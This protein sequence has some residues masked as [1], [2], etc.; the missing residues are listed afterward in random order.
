MANASVKAPEGL[1][2]WHSNINALG[3]TQPQLAAV[4]LAWAEQHGH[5]FLHFE[6][7]TP[8]GTWIEGLTKEPFFQSDG[9]PKVSWTKKDRNVPIFFQYGIG[10]PPYLFKVIRSLPTEALSLIV[11]EPSIALLAYT[12]HM[13]HVYSA[14]PA[15]TT[16]TFVV[17]ADDVPEGVKFARTDTGEDV[18]ERTRERFSSDESLTAFLKVA[19]LNEALSSNLRI[20]GLF[21]AAQSK[22]ST[23]DGEEDA[24]GKEMAD[25]A[26]EIREWL[27]VSLG[28]LGNSAHDTMLGLRQMSLM[29]PWIVYGSK[30]SSLKEE[31]AGR[32]F[33]VVSAGPSLA[34]NVDL[35]RD[36]KDRCV[37]V[38]NDAT[39]LKLLDIGI[40]PHIVCSLER[41]L[42]TY[43]HLIRR[44]VMKYPEECAKILLVC[45]AVC[46]PNTYGTWPGPKIIVG[47]GEIPVDKWFV[48]G[49]LGGTVMESGSSVAHM[50]LG[51]AQELGASSVALI[52]QDLAYG[53]DGATHSDGVFDDGMKAYFKNIKAREGIY[54][55]EGALGGTVET[56]SLWIQFLR[57][58]EQRAAESDIDIFDCTEGG[59][60]IRGT[61]IEPFKKY[62]ADHVD[63]ASPFAHTP[64]EV[65]ALAGTM[66]DKSETFA[67]I[68][69]TFEKSRRDIDEAGALISKMK[70]SIDRVAA[71]ALTPKMRVEL[72]AKT[73]AMLDR[74]NELNPMFAFIAQS[75]LYLATTEIA[76]ARF[77]DTVETV[78]RWVDVHSEILVA[79]TAVLT[80]VKE[81][82]DHAYDSLRFYRDNDLSSDPIKADDAFPTLKQISDTLG[83]GHDQLRLRL[84]MDSFFTR[85]DMTTSEW[86][87]EVIWQ[88]AMFLFKEGRAQ[89]ATNYMNRVAGL[90]DEKELPSDTIFSFLKDYARVLMTPDLCSFPNYAT[91]RNVLRNAE[92]YGGV[93]D[94]V[95]ALKVELARRES[96]I[97]VDYAMMNTGYPRERLEKWFN[98][99]VKAD[100]SMSSNDPLEAFRAIWYGVRD[101][102]VLVPRLSSPS[103]S[104]LIAQMVK[105]LEADDERVQGVLDEILN[106]MAKNL[107]VFRKVPAAVPLIFL[108]ALADHGADVKVPHNVMEIIAKAKEAAAAKEPAE[109]K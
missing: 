57:L 28:N 82:V 8:A 107:S 9:D 95:R 35:L 67:Q 89:E 17:S 96:S 98:A 62:I 65:V 60:L 61:K 70:E 45:Q 87:G 84:A 25:M 86:P 15:G 55:V 6:N 69:A 68:E 81:W 21:T 36:I 85:C 108:K 32:P 38:A 47:K 94:D 50:C 48:E 27:L 31:F 72:A 33:V 11:V 16:L 53:A 91:A 52:G 66:S 64:A 22:F 29:S 13:T 99:R 106:D 102:G 40:T 39:A 51:L 58:F 23:H 88:C 20:H 49:T 104:W 63:G 37:I 14:L 73:A 97:N 41:G 12:L 34:K 7:K 109:A 56:S 43:N 77:L 19:L 10:T 5:E 80:F 105:F 3:K 46:V 93:D 4:L 103:F 74:L 79:H 100:D 2:V 44:P 59:A 26:H 92:S 90:F 78:R 18:G 83:D 54:K 76:T 42:V 30:L 101:H 71:P 1:E 75:Y 24:F